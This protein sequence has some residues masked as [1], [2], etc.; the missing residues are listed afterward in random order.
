MI[1][2]FAVF[3]FYFAQQT[4]KLSDFIFTCY[5]SNQNN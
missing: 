3:I 1:R 5:R 2:N 4:N